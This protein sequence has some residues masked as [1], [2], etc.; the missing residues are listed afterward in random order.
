[1]LSTHISMIGDELCEICDRSYTAFFDADKDADLR[2]PMFATIYLPISLPSS[3][4]TFDLNQSLP[5]NQ[6]CPPSSPNSNYLSKTSQRRLHLSRQ[7][8]QIPSTLTIQN[9]QQSHEEE[10]A[11]RNSVLRLFQLMFHIEG[12]IEEDCSF[13]ICGGSFF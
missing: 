8:N 3:L 10:S 5:T 12:K 9:K 13:E 7:K 6:Q 2:T 4:P 1:M 11:H